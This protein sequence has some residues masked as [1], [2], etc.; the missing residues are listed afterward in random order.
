MKKRTL[1]KVKNSQKIK[2]DR[3]PLP[4]RYCLLTL[5][6][7]FVLVGGFFFAARQHFASIEYGIKNSKLKAQLDEAA[8]DKRR[9]LLEKEIALTPTEIKKAAK[10]FGL[11]ET[12]GAP[13]ASSPAAPPAEANKTSDA[14]KSAKPSAE[15]R[16]TAKSSSDAKLKSTVSNDMAD[17]TAKF[18]KE[19]KKPAKT[20]EPKAL[21]KTGR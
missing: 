5:V 20:G 21:S 4:W 16:E 3:D 7:G 8:A 1:P 18:D 14:D 19:S 13:A 9:L 6:C 10:K 15:K 12:D 11:V 17:K 2:R